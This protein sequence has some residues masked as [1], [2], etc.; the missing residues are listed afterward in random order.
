VIGEAR[1]VV[2]GSGGLGTSAAYHRP[3]S[4]GLL[5]L[6]GAA[7]R[8]VAGDAAR[9]PG[10]LT[11]GPIEAWLFREPR[12]RAAL[13]QAVESRRLPHRRRR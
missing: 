5:G 8:Q 11:A 6:P 4:A 13:G 2:I 1:V 9:H 7:L 3:G 12:R 10:A